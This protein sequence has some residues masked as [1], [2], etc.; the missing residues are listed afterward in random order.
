MKENIKLCNYGCIINNHILE[1]ESDLMKFVGTQWR[2][3]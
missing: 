1:L 3:M 2:S